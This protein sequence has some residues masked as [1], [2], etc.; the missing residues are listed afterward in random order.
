MKILID[1][2]H[3]AHVHLFKNFAWIMQK[4]GHEILFT[5]RE[6]EFELYLLKKYG[7]KFYSFGKKYNSKPGKLWGLLK[8]D[9]KEFF[10]GLR[11][12]PDIFLSHGSMYA[13]HAAFFLKKPHI[14][15]EDTFN[16]EQV[17]LYLPFTDTVLTPDYDH[18]SLGDKEIRYAGYHELAYLHPN[19][20]TPKK[21]PQFNNVVLL[22]FV[23]WNATHDFKHGGIDNIVKMN[24]ITLLESYGY[25]VLISSEG[26][27][28]G[29]LIKYRINIKPEEIHDV[30]SNI[31][32]F[33]GEGATM[34][35]EAAL[36][37][38]PS[39]YIN[40][41]KA[42]IGDLGDLDLI[43]HLKNNEN[44]LK[45]IKSFIHNENIKNEWK[46]KAESIIKNKID[47]TAF[48]VWFV[49][50]YPDSRIIMKKNPH[51]QYRFK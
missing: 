27:L 12:K 25:R 22:R 34:A 49:E 16:F 9:V 48:L 6:K 10:T 32:L 40:S 2:G 38:T 50:N 17:K 1:I 14:A 28:P 44:L 13:A 33:I 7:F 21:L 20:F 23:A 11:F 4:K 43:L 3:P 29:E 51:Y 41:R 5:C 36:L 8:F 37:G 39:I 45:I 15:F 46:N 30:L 47:V 31:S 18:P 42:C 24:L 35:N 26:E 19:N